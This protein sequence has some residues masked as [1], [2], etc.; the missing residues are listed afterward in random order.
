MYHLRK[1]LS[2]AAND[3]SFLEVEK[4]PSEFLR[5]LEKLFNYSPLQTISPGQSPSTKARSVTT[6]II[7]ESPL[8]LT[9]CYQI[10]H[11]LCFVDRS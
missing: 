1:Q 2:K 4:D 10:V 7:C 6:N 8:L 5:T 3:K 11:P 9:T